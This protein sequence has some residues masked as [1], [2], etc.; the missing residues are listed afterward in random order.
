MRDIGEVT[1]FDF[2]PRVQQEV[3]AAIQAGAQI[4]TTQLPEMSA[5]AV[6]PQ[7]HVITLQQP[8]GN[9]DASALLAMAAMD[10]TKKSSKF[11]PALL[12]AAF[13]AAAIGG[14]VIVAKPKIPGQSATETTT[15]PIVTGDTPVTDV[16]GNTQVSPRPPRRGARSGLI[17][18]TSQE[19]TGS[20]DSCYTGFNASET[21]CFTGGESVVTANE[22]GQPETAQ[23][24]HVVVSDVDGKTALT[25]ADAESAVPQALAGSANLRT[26]LGSYLCEVGAGQDGVLVVYVFGD[27]SPDDAKIITR[28]EGCA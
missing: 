21:V 6:Q 20:I 23:V 18:P 10:R 25:P 4:N 14:Y 5:T 3:E 1:S 24:V 9:S 8:A 28:T 12:G 7:I 2:R 11:W 13:T 19:S 26:A 27:E 16:G 22:N 15:S 17:D